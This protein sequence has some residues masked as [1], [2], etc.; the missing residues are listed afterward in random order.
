ML[1]KGIYALLGLIDYYVFKL[2][3]TVMGVIMAIAD[4][5]IFSVDQIEEIANRVYIVV[6]VLILFKL[7]ISAVQFMVNPDQFDD[8]EK[9]LGGILKKTVITIIMIT[10]APAIFN[11]MIAIQSTIIEELPNII[12]GTAQKSDEE[13]QK[14]TDD[15]I[16]SV[17]SSFV[18]PNKDKGGKEIGASD[19]I[20]DLESFRDHVSDG[21]ERG[22]LLG[23][24]DAANCQYNYM[25]IIST[26]A[27]GFLCYVLLSMT[28]DVAIRMFKFGIIRILAPI[29]ISSYVFSKDKLSKFIKTTMTVYCDL[30]IRLAIVYFII[31]AAEKIVE[32]DIVQSISGDNWFR[33]VLVN[34]AIFGGLFMFAK[35]A[36]K[37]RTS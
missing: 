19:G 31:F 24:G 20:H 32:T 23:A 34:I 11:F 13:K 25:I 28:L 16:F 15:V 3:S 29:P 5:Q 6:G 36:P 22:G 12:F 1:I 8:K 30:F 33:D 7:V 35:S 14:T 10:V 21:C 27:G 18:R 17:L 4:K 37:F 9:G 26:I 2:A